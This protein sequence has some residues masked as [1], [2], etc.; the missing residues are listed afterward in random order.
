MLR[1]DLTLYRFG[2]TELVPLAADPTDGYLHPI[3]GKLA[4]GE[5]AYVRC[6][7][8]K[9]GILYRSGLLNPTLKSKWP[10]QARASALARKHCYVR[11]FY[12]SPG[13]ESWGQG[14]RYSCYA[15]SDADI[16]RY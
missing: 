10:G 1:C 2:A 16:P 15:R 4:K 6:D 12:H 9:H 13:K 8:A 11:G 3:C 7:K 14:G 5:I